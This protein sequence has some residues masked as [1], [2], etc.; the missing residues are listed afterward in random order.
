MTSSRVVSCVRVG[1]RMPE[2]VVSSHSMMLSVTNTKAQLQFLG[3]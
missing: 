3:K 2:G 1:V